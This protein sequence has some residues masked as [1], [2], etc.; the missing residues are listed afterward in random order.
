[1]SMNWQA[2]VTSLLV[3]ACAAYSAWTLMPAALRQ[4]CRLTLGQSQPA[5]DAGGCG[6]CNGCAAKKPT[7]PAAEQVVNFVRRQPGA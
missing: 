1:M 7:A 5:V 4:R 3:L 2:V 6:G